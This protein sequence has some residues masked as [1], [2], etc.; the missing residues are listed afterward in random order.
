M[1][2]SVH[3]WVTVSLLQVFCYNIAVHLFSYIC[4]SLCLSVSVT[5]CT[6]GS[7]AEHEQQSLPSA[8]SKIAHHH[9]LLVPRSTDIHTMQMMCSLL[10]GAFLYPEELVKCRCFATTVWQRTKRCG[11]PALSTS[12]WGAFTRPAPY[13]CCLDWPQSPPCWSCTSSWLPCMG[14]AASSD[15]DPL[16]SKP[17][18]QRGNAMQCSRIQ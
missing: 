6:P 14:W 11:R 15:P 3:L 13:P 4:L 9:A 7:L 5:V 18:T 16:S 10:Q 12:S 2:L 17:C 1:C 8:A